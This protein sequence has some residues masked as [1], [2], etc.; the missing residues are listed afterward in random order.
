MPVKVYVKY[1]YLKIFD[2]PGWSSGNAV[3]S[4]SGSAQFQS[5]LRHELCQLRFFMVFYSPS[6]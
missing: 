6:K 5:R 3:D 2:L 4:D 1:M